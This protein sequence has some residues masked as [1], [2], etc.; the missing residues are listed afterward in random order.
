MGLKAVYLEDGVI[1]LTDFSEG[2]GGLVRCY[3]DGRIE[4]FEIPIYGGTERPY[5]NFPTICAA[6][7]LA[8]TWT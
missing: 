4:L 5:G 2:G 3:P 7:S 1:E 8:K 6:L